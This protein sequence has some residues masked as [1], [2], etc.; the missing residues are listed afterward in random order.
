MLLNGL[1]KAELARLTMMLWVW[2]SNE[3]NTMS[4]KVFSSVF[5][6]MSFLFLVACYIIQVDYR[7]MASAVVICGL[8]FATV[9][10][11]DII[12]SKGT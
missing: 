10:I 5:G 1:I 9:L 7:M 12:S 3:R 11:R 4:V 6:V 8:W 2:F